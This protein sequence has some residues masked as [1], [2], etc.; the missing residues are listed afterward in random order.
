MLDKIRSDPLDT[1]SARSPADSAAATAEL[2][3]TRQAIFE[4]GSILVKNH[5]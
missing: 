4:K 5:E 1:M 3:A 2:T